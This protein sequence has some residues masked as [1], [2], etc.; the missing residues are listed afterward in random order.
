M[1][2]T[3]ITMMPLQPNDRWAI[4]AICTIT[5]VG[6]DPIKCKDIQIIVKDK[7]NGWSWVLEYDGTNYS[8]PVEHTVA[9]SF[10]INYN[11]YAFYDPNKNG[12]T[13]IIFVFSSQPE[14]VSVQ[15]GGTV[16]SNGG[17]IGV[18]LE[19][20]GGAEYSVKN[21]GILQTGDTVILCEANVTRFGLSGYHTFWYDSDVPT[22]LTEWVADVFNTYLV[23]QYGFK[24]IWNSTDVPADI[25]I[26]IVH[27]PTKS[28]IYQGTVTV[29]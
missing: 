23:P 2:S 13:P 6:G 17:T 5:H 19:Q 26:T 22:F 15:G 24:N 4:D 14:D 28:I 1:T 20:F 27:V 7:T 25:E 12:W 9:S 8:E 3:G 11:F 29:Q 10:T 18:I 16:T 21:D